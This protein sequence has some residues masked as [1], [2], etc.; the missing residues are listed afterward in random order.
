MSLRHSLLAILTAEDMTGYDL[1]KYFDG[2]VAY[3]WSAPHSQIYPELRKMEAANL[4]KATEVPRGQK[5]TKREYSITEAGKE[6]LRRWVMEIHSL[7]AERDLSRLKAA[8]ID[9]G[10]YET[11]RRQLQNHLNHWSEVSSQRKLVIDDVN[12]D[13]VPLLNRRLEIRPAEEHRAIKELKEF[14]FKGSVYRAEAEIRWAKE[15][16]A[17]LDDLEGSGVPLTGESLDSD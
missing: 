10:S 12:A 16:L 4:I 5:A 15:G 1:V 13:A 9:W 8:Y 14:A 2:T 17:L 11:G 7:P 6:E 3:L